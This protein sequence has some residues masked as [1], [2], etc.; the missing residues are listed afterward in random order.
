[1][2]EAGRQPGPR[3]PRLNRDEEGAV[4]GDET[5]GHAG[6]VEGQAGDAISIE[7]DEAAGA[8]ATTGEEFDGGFCG[9]RGSGAGRTKEVRGS[10]RHHDFHDGFAEAGRG[11]AAGFAVGVASA[12]DEGRIADAA[13]KF[14]T[15]AAGGSGR[16]KMAMPI[17]SDSTDG[18]LLVAAMVFGGVGILA[19]AEPGVAFSR[20]DK[21]FGL[22]KRDTLI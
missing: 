7:K 16:E 13:G 18:A 3:P 14:A 1:M 2:P 11:N 17:E 9:T 6:S 22:A 10:F 21:L 15:R 12:A 19:A 20:G 4:G 8:L 5:V